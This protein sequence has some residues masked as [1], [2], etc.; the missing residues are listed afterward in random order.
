[1]GWLRCPL[2]RSRAC[3][4]LI[5]FMGKT[6]LVHAP[7]ESFLLLHLNLPIK[8]GYFRYNLTF[9]THARPPLLQE[10]IHWLAPC[11]VRKAEVVP[12]DLLNVCPS[13]IC[14]IYTGNLHSIITAPALEME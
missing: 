14:I 1:M 7:A 10:T 12:A 6:L 5:M 4:L 3:I 2:R 9:M 8:Y 11:L 13:S